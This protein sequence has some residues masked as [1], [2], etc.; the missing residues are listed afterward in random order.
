MIEVKNI[1]YRYTGSRH[2]VFKDFSLTFQPNRI[3]GLLGKN[4]TGKSTLLY[5]ISGLLHPKSGTIT[6]DGNQS[7]RRLPQTLSE[8]FIVPEEYDLPNMSLRQFIKV[9]RPFYPRFSEEVLNKCLTAFEMTK[10]IHLKELSRT[11]GRK[12]LYERDHQERRERRMG[13]LRHHQSGRLLLPELL[14]GQYRRHSRGAGQ[15]SV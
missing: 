8:I 15:R 13:A 6:V 3:Y 7:T 1:S 11:P 4:G 5:L 9:N 12:G 10:D 2:Q 14:R